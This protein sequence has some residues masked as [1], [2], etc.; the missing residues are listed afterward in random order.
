M[1]NELRNKNKNLISVRRN[2]EKKKNKTVLPKA[3]IHTGF[4]PLDLKEV[5]WV[6]LAKE[7]H[8]QRVK[9]QVQE[10]ANVCPRKFYW[11]LMQVRGRCVQ[12]RFLESHRTAA[13]VGIRTRGDA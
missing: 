11:K 8:R 3:R 1:V 4:S 10:L 9:T 13:H 5:H 7:L 12:S 2:L 6:V